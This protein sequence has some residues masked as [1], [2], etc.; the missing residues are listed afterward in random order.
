F[1]SLIRERLLLTLNEAEEILTS[2]EGADLAASTEALGKARGHLEAGEIEQAADLATQLKAQLET[3]RRQGEEAEAALRRLRDV[4]A[5]AEAMNTPL[6]R[7]S[8]LLDRAERAYRMGQFD[9]ALDIVAQADVD[10]TKER[11]QAVASIMKRLEGVLDRQGPRLGQPQGVR[12]R[13]L[14]QGARHGDPR[15]RFHR[16]PA[17]AARR[18]R[19]GPGEGEGAPADRGGRRC[20]RLE[21]REGVPRRRVRVRA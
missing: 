10:A 8:G 20:G 12:G 11:D 19:G 13:G 21:V 5:D 9:E 18:S 4:L 14:R 3:L 16:G 7:T 15:I 1:T 2:V 17:R 6:P